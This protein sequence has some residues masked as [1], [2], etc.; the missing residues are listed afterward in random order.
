MQLFF[1][2][3]I[4]PGLHELAADEAKH[5]IQVLRHQVGDILTI[6]NGQGGWYEGRIVAANKRHCQLEVQLLRQEHTRAACK[7]TI[8]IAPTK[9]G[10]RFEWFLEK[11]TEIGVDTIQPFISQHSERRSIRPERLTKVLESAMK[12]S[13]QAWLPQLLPLLPLGQ[14]IGQS[15]SAAK[16]IAW[17]DEGVKSPIQHNYQAGQD[18][19]ILIGP[20][21]GFSLEEAQIAQAAGFKAVSL[22]ANRLRTETAA[23][24]AAQTIA[25]LNWP[26]APSAH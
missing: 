5:A 10:D 24:V 26:N 21:G 19:S 16:L 14:A 15:H 20:E 25:Q 3:N 8:A 17:I 7:S 23:V 18:V 13:L 1:D 12:Q 9:S 11:A 22:G 2:A 4:Q 6:V